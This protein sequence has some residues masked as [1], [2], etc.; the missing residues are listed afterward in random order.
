MAGVS[1][2]WPKS[3]IKIVANSTV[4]LTNDLDDIKTA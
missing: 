2:H 4:A 1:K 3:V